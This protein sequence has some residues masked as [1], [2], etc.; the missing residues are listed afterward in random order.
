MII[1]RLNNFN[2]NLFFF[3]E[4]V[5][6]TCRIISKPVTRNVEVILRS[7]VRKRGFDN[8]WGHFLVATTGW[9]AAGI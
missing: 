7:L 2:L 6:A 9:T 8:A 5:E 1:G 4:C 3:I